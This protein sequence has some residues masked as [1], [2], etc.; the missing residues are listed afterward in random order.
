MD[1][2][3]IL[4]ARNGARFYVTMR[5]VYL[6]YTPEETE[7]RRFPTYDIA[8]KARKAMRD[9]TLEIIEKQ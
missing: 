9:W 8:R 7:A 5:G 2:F 3:Y 6:A 4:R 1:K